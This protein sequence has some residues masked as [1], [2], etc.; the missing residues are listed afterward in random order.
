MIWYWS[1]C[2]I[3]LLFQVA[4]VLHL[5]YRLVVQPNTSRAHTFAESF[6]S[7]GGIETL[8]VL[9]Q[10][11]AKAGDHST[12]GSSNGYK[13]EN[14]PAQVSGSGVVDEKIHDDTS[15]PVEGI[16][17][18]AQADSF[19]PLFSGSG[20]TPVDV[21]V[22]TSLSRRTSV[23]ENLLVKTLGGINFS[24]SADS[25]RNN[26]YNNDNG[27]GIVV[28]IISLLGALVASGHL[29]FGAQTLPNMTSSILVNGL[30]DGGGTM[31]DDKV[32]L[33]LFALQKAFQ[34]APRRLMTSNVYM[35]LLAASV[36]LGF[37]SYYFNKWF[38]HICGMNCQRKHLI[39]NILY[40]YETLCIHLHNSRYTVDMCTYFYLYVCTSSYSWTTKLSLEQLRNLLLIKE[41]CILHLKCVS[42]YLLH[43]LVV[44]NL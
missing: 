40:C 11:E 19:E 34:A 12:N 23:S 33:L 26:V 17:S 20:N 21:S 30:H 31:F 7:C 41:Y 16:D 25:A 9:L 4:R 38:F 37:I 22:I 27:D 6:I 13:E 5:I 36:W 18:V 8:L 32:S 14:N 29:K 28:R 24:I 44:L 42:L 35:A 2:L 39:S 1:G 43:I 15:V 3:I 10:R